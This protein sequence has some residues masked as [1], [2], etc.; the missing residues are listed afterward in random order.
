MQKYILC[1]FLLFAQLYSYAQFSLSKGNDNFQI[2][3]RSCTFYNYRFYETDETNLKKNRFRLRDMQVEFKS[4]FGNQWKIVL[5][6]DLA[7]FAS[8][9]TQ[10][11]DNGLMEAHVTYLPFNNGPEVK[12]G[13]DKLPYSRSSMTSLYSTPF[14]SRSEVASGDFFARR[15]VGLT[16][17]QGFKNDRIIFYGGAYTGLGEA[18]LK[19]DNDASGNLEYLGRVELSYPT[20]FRYNDIDDKISQRPMFSVGANARYAEKKTDSGVDYVIKTV[21]GKKKVMGVDFAF[22]WKGFSFLY[23]IHK[24]HLIPNDTMRVANS[25]ANYINAGGYLCQLVYKYKPWHSVVGVR[26]DEINPNDLIQNDINRSIT[27]S[28]RYTFPS[29]NTSL[30]VNYMYRLPYANTETK[31]KRDDLRV[32]IV[33]NF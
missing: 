28:Y 8:G 29:S 31:W 30:M 25:G 32:G 27:Y 21:N 9:S 33:T 6:A 12:F 2:S 3:L 20:K 7:D 26:Y 4:K 17:T 23:E 14:F 10:D 19:G 13:F 5:Q 24:A 16:L 22:Q 15:D 1:F 18:S 11:E